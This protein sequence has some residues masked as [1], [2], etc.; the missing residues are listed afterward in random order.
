MR[1]YVRLLIGLLRRSMH[2]RRD[3]LIENLV[4]RQQLAVYAR[5]PR[6]ARL[7]NEDRLFWPVVARTWSP[8]R[9]RLRLMQP[10]TWFDGTARSGVGTGHGRVAAAGQVGL[11]LRPHRTLGLDSPE[12]REPQSRPSESAYLRRR[13]VLDGLINEYDWAA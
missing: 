3:L 9:T 8:W 4:L 5:Q 7:R 2:E 10:D 11:R 1:L 13:E 12:G 6:R